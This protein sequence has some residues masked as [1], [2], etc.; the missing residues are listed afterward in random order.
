ML[1]YVVVAGHHVAPASTGPAAAALS[2]WAELRALRAALLRPSTGHRRAAPP[3]PPQLRPLRAVHGGQRCVTR[4]SPGVSLLLLFGRLLSSSAQLTAAN[5]TAAA[6]AAVGRSEAARKRL[7]KRR[8]EGQSRNGLKSA[9]LRNCGRV[10][11]RT[12]RRKPHGKPTPVRVWWPT[13]AT[14]GAV[15]SQ[16]TPPATHERA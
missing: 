15:Q 1:Y 14:R 12:Q 2:R 5:T 9:C 7:P 11:P 16:L 10:R 13:T 6:A 4:P 3:G 8:S